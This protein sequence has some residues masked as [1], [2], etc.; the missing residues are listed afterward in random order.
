M[1]PHPFVRSV[2]SPPPL[3]LGRRFFSPYRL[4]Q[5]TLSLSPCLSVLCG[6]SM[7]WLTPDRRGLDVARGGNEYCTRVG[8][9]A[10]WARETL[11]QAP[12]RYPPFSL[13]SSRSYARRSESSICVSLSRKA[14]FE[15]YH[16]G[17]NF[18]IRRLVPP[19]RPT[20]T[21]STSVRPLLALLF[22]RPTT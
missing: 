13:L 11:V 18:S 21:S 8:R 3:S 10:R 1:S 5:S 22:P 14:A 12:E 15:R 4:L 17:R 19:C 16:S 20:P 6:K 7:M 2:S 9:A